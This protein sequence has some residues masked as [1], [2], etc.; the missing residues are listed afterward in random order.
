MNQRFAG[1]RRQQR[2]ADLH[3]SVSNAVQGLHKHQLVVVT[4]LRGDD[5]AFQ[6]TVLEEHRSRVVQAQ[7][8]IDALGVFVD[9]CRADT[10]LEESAAA[11]LRAG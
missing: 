9:R 7:L 5:A 8:V 1:T 4:A 11:T 2:L 3:R 10:L 6:Q